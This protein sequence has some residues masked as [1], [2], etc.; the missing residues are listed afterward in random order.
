LSN[1][2]YPEL[3]PWLARLDAHPICGHDMQNYLQYATMF[4]EHGLLCLD[5]LLGISVEELQGM[6]TVLNL[7]TACHLIKWASEDIKELQGSPLKIRQQ[8]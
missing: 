6:C 1:T 8:S 7:G 5:D 2:D 3:T 4:T